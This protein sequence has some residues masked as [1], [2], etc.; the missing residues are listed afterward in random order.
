MLKCRKKNDAWLISL[1]KKTGGFLNLV[2]AAKF[3]QPMV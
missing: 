3:Y 1:K 2:Q